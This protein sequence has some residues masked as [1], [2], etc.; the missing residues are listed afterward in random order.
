MEEKGRRFQN[1]TK[2]IINQY[3]KINVW[4]EDKYKE[5]NTN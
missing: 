5:I 3:R 4:P 1:V 2:K